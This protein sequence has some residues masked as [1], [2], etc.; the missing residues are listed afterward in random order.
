MDKL[1]FDYH[2]KKELEHINP[3]SKTK[4]IENKINVANQ[5]LVFINGSIANANIELNNANEELIIIKNQL[6]N[7]ELTVEE[8][9]I[10]KEKK[11]IIEEK[12]IIAQELKK[13]AKKKERIAKE[14]LKKYE[15]SLNQI[16]KV[17]DKRPTHWGGLSSDVFFHALKVTYNSFFVKPFGWGFQ[18]YEL[19]F[20][21]YNKK[22]N[23]HKK[24]LSSFNNKDASNMFFKMITEFGIFSL[25]IYLLLLFIFFNNKISIENKIFLIPFII[26]QNIRGAGYFNGAFLFIL[27]LL[28]VSQFAKSKKLKDEKYLK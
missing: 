21:D 3:F 25:A 19:A 4:K 1:V 12:K 7:S 16:D 8:E 15:E 24:S 2:N 18:G 14:K 20:K 27:L 6:D 9:R 11:R 17:I 26:T 22:N 5:E 28:I 10:A 13:I 23:V